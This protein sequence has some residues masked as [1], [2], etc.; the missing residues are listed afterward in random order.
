[1]MKSVKEQINDRVRAKVIRQG[2]DHVTDQD[3]AHQAIGL[4]KNQVEGQVGEQI[5]YQ[6]KVHLKI[7][8]FNEIN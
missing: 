7:K 1:M 2:M 6:V 4:V 3:G 5:N 8:V